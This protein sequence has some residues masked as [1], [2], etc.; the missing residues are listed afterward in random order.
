MS[1]SRGD[2]RVIGRLTAAPA[3]SGISFTD[4]GAHHLPDIPDQWPLFAVGSLEKSRHL[5][6]RALA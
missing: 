4:R 2:V 6:G 1:Q 5:I 3:G